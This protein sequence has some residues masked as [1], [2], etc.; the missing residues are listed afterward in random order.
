MFAHPLPD[1]RVP[2]LLSAHDEKLIGQDARAILEYLNRT[3][4]DND[5]TVAVASTLLRL[6]RVRRHR[7]LCGPPT[8]PNSRPACP[9]W[10]TATSTR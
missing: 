8:A 10:P 7:A 3:G 5:P 1:G 9:R 2:V 4:E 6:R